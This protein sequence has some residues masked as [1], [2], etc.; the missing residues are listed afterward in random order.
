[1]KEDR[2]PIASRSTLWANQTAQYL[3]QKNITPNQISVCSMF[4]A[5]LGTLALL[6]LQA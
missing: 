3:A 6:F 2:R 5:L 4:F 1:M